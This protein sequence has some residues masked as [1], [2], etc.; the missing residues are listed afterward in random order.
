[1]KLLAVETATKRQSVAILDGT[2]VLCQSDEEAGRNHAKWLVATIDRLLRSSGL[3]L[4]ALEGLAVSIGPG[5]FTGL[6]VGLAT[7]MGFRMAAGLPLAAV[8]TLEA[9][10][11]N[12]RGEAR[13][14]C[15]VL[16]ARTGEV[17]WA[18]Y[19][20]DSDGRL[21]RMTEERVGPLES[22]AAAIQG[23]IVMLGEGWLI[24]RD[25]L[26]GLLKTR[27]LD[28][29]DAPFNAMAASAASV[30]LAGLERLARGDVAAQGLAPLYVQRAEAEVRW[31]PR[32]AVLQP[33]KG[34]GRS[35]KAGR[36]TLCRSEGRP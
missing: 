34:L 20:W 23:P 7:L 33:T 12:L 29:G 26:R 28:V 19:R 1:M 36:G 13:T 32:A 4:S 6:R 24:Y 2:N 22:L 11:W 14:L 31:R 21:I 15:P 5:S 18:F 27:S 9:M 3:T 10:A 16:Q 35:N 17:Y 8:P 25:E 30:G